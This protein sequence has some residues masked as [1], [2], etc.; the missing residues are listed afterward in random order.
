M[1]I[2]IF[3]STAED[4]Q[5]SNELIVS[6]QPVLGDCVIKTENLM[7]TNSEGIPSLVLQVMMLKKTGTFPLV[8]VDDKAVLSGTMPTLLQ[9]QGFIHNGV[10]TPPILVDRADSAVDF[11][12]NSRLHVSV[13]VSNIENSLPFYKVLFGQ[14]PVKIKL[15][16]AKFELVEPSLNITLN[17]FREPLKGGP[18]NHFGIQVKSSDAV[19]EVKKRYEE[20]G[21]IVE[22]EIATACCYAVQTKIW[23]ADPDGIKWEVY[24]VTEAEAEEGC[25][26]DCI[27]F[28]ELQP[29]YI[30]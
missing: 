9:L 29:S 16:Y 17:Q 12:G 28:L 5:I 10:D 18:I 20:A 23:V 14:E 7:G 13:D 21:F 30:A 15:N 6:L 24:V 8:I 27:C 1:N 2:K 4:L 25:G 19:L 3:V 11:P 22:E 26:P